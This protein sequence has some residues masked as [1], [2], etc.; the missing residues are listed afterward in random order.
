MSN[1]DVAICMDQGSL[2]QVINS[3]FNRQSLRAKLFNGSQS[4]TLAGV[5]VQVGWEVLVPPTVTLTPPT[6]EQWS[7][8]VKRDGSTAQPTG[9]AFMVTFPQ[10]HVLRTKSNGEQ[11]EATT[12]VEAIC[13]VA[14]VNDRLSITPLAAIVNLSGATDFDTVIYKAIIIP[15][16]L[17]MAG[18]MLA[19]E[20]IPAISFQGVSFGPLTLGV[21]GGR[22]IGVAALVG[23]PTPQPPDPGSL[24]GGAPFYVLLSPAALNQMASVGVQQ[25]A[26]KGASTSG[27]Q[28][29]GIGSADYNA[30]IRLDNA[31]AG[32]D[33]GDLTMINAQVGISAAAS[34]GITT[35]VGQVI[36]DIGNG[37]VSVVNQIG[38]AFKSY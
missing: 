20:Q 15:Q 16:V 25:M 6:A 18:Q 22:L 38:D 8:S 36:N 5:Q 23:Q 7:S 24:P 30:S 37:V 32:I 9:N 27:S 17:N 26:G 31:S 3:I 34:A 21:G 13:T 4:T 28:G 35:V 1:F 33:P 14:I 10:L 11:S 12:S 29:F 2:N 19:G